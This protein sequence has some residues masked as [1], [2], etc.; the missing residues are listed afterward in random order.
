[1]IIRFKQD[2]FDLYKC[3]IFHYLFRTEGQLR[4]SMGL[5]LH[6]RKFHDRLKKKID[7]RQ[8]K[9]EFGV[10]AFPSLNELCSKMNVCVYIWARYG[11]RS[12]VELAWKSDNEQSCDTTVHL[13]SFT[14]HKFTNST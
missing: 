9:I 13:L 7:I 12:A 5:N 11:Q 8:L 2:E 1:M 4:E 10:P 6:C 14:F 3:L